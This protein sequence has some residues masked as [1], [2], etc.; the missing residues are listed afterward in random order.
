MTNA[1]I[2]LGS[3]SNIKWLDSM[4]YFSVCVYGVAVMG[5]SAIRYPSTCSHESLCSVLF[6]YLLLDQQEQIL[7][8][9]LDAF[10]INYINT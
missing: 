6:R 2:E 10:V 3:S 4:E 8:F 1:Y 5:K 7:F 9:S